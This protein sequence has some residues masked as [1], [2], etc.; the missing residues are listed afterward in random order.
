MIDKGMNIQWE[1]WVVEKLPQ[2]LRKPRIMALCMVLCLPV[3]RLYSDFLKWK[4]QAR[5]KA[6]GSPQV[7]MLQ[8]IVKDSLDINLQILEGDGKPIDF[9][10]K[11]E[12][13]GMDKERQFFALIDRYKLAGKSY[14]YENA[15]VV[16]GMGWTGY[17]C[18][19]GE[20]AFV[21][22]WG[23]FVC[24]KNDRINTITVTYYWKYDASW[25]ATIIKRLTLKA[26]SPVKSDLKIKTLM[27]LLGQTEGIEATLELKK[28]QN[29]FEVDTWVMDRHKNE[30][31][32]P[33]SDESY[34]YKLTIKD[35]YE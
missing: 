32:S 15:K 16:Y 31:V 29:F 25:G 33:R 4:K 18:E 19:K 12:F 28:G 6:G 17:V 14:S 11:T 27:F 34:N 5:I 13:I 10:V 7:C 35:V 30:S 23:R 1:K 20:A 8:K 26:D 24:E 9:I 3:E 22:K 2:R 21:S